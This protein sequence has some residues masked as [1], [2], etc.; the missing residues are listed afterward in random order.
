MSILATSILVG[1]T[2]LA[3]IILTSKLKLDAFIALFLVSVFLAFAVL[4]SKT[5]VNK[6][7]RV[8]GILWLQ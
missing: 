4:P 8:S 3:I 1:I 6:S 2:I 7:S 5:I